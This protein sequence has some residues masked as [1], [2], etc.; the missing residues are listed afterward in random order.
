[1]KISKVTDYAA[2]NTSN[3]S[4]CSSSKGSLPIGHCH[5]DV[6]TYEY[7]ATSVLVH[8]S[9]LAMTVQFLM[10]DRRQSNT[11]IPSTNVDNNP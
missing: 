6:K 7:Y 1:M 4:K 3:H 10:A 8:Y 9:A 11:L 5:E 2:L